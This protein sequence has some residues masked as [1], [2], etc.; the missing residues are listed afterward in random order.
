MTACRQKAVISLVEMCPGVGRRPSRLPPSGLDQALG[1][2]AHQAGGGVRANFAAVIRRRRC[3]P[4]SGSRST[5]RRRRG[6][7]FRR[8]ASTSGSAY[9]PSSPR[10]AASP[11]PRAERKHA[12][13]RRPAAHAAVPSLWPRPARRRPR[14]WA[15][16]AERLGEQLALGREVPVDRS[17]RHTRRLGHHRHMGAA[18][19]DFAYAARTACRMRSRLS[20]S[21]LD[22]FGAAVGHV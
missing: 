2:S 4:R 18:E 5:H 19:S 6:V 10:R 21:V 7:D 11:A 16:R 13:G 8:A 1:Q 14:G 12:V 9:P 3:N 22:P 15:L 17:G 20:W